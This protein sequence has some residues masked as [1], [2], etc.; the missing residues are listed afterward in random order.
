MLVLIFYLK[1][2]EKR[3]TDLSSA[4]QLELPWHLPSETQGSRNI[5]NVVF[6]MKPNPGIKKMWSCPKCGRQFKRRGQTH[7]CR[8]FSIKQH[9]ESKPEG[10]LLYENFKRAVKKRVGAFKIESLECCIHFVSTF[11]FAAVKIFKDKIRV[12]FSLGR[13]INNKRINQF[14]QL[15]ANRY[16]Y[17]IDIGIADEIDE[18]LIEWIQEAQDKK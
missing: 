1:L 8:Q 3:K 4:L 13:K 10:K 6:T 18:E 5:F 14:Q 11:T 15:S 17:F 7:S 9:F 2:L 16:L 12:D